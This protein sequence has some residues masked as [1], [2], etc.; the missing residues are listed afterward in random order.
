M[1]CLPL[2]AFLSQHANGQ[3]LHLSQFY[4]TPLYRNPALAGI[5]KG[6]VRVQAVF[7]SQWNSFANAYKTG[8][9]NAEYKS[10]L[11]EAD[12]FLTWG[13]MSYYD[14]SG[15]TDLTT[16]IVMPAVNF[17]K[18]I[19]QNRNQYLSVGFMGGF[20]QRRIDRSK[21]TTNSQYDT[22]LDG[23]DQLNNGYTYWDGSAGIS[24]NSSLGQ[25]EN[26]NLVIGLAY[27]HFTK[28]RNSFFGDSR[29][30]L[31]PK[32]VLSTDLK[33]ELNDY[34]SVT[35]YS[36]FTKQGANT[37]MAGGILYG[38]KIGDFSDEPDY[39]IHG[40]AFMRLND[41]IIPTIRLDYRPFSVGVS[42][43]INISQLAA[44][45]SG[46]GGFEFSVT[47][48]GFIDRYHSSRDALKC[49]RF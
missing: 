24:Y 40:G 25:N 47:Y 14:R 44:K 9:L 16:T 3:D 42:Y 38:L 11:G 33:M 5:M 20:V 21:I 41:A 37:E 28:P 30:T 31:D 7:R 18:S 10:K 6:D 46:R 29:T 13:L 34:S 19:S 2:L 27:H 17:H 15:T 22:G 32:I 8:S 36:D 43:D 39:M 45:S 26:N 1:V 48:I 12:D 49:P 4:E 23:E 35:I